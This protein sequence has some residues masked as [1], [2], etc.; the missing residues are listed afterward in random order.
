MPKIRVSSHAI[1]RYRVRVKDIPDAEA[2]QKILEKVGFYAPKVGELKIPVSETQVAVVANR[3]VVT[4]LPAKE[5]RASFHVQSVDY[6]KTF[7]G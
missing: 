5:S 6:R 1:H 7:H 4:I 3:V 2:K